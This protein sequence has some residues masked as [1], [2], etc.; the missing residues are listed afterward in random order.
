VVGRVGYGLARGG[1][2]RGSGGG[3][4]VTARVVRHGGM[5]RIGRHRVRVWCARRC[6]EDKKTSE[7]VTMLG[8]ICY[9]PI[10]YL[11]TS[12]TLRSPCFPL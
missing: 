3:R 1:K 11:T 10:S 9:T 7:D 2:A 8:V 12:Y 5:R 6:A 4:D